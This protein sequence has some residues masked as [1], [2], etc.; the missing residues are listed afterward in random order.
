MRF[1]KVVD[2][3]RTQLA[4]KDVR[5]PAGRWQNPG[6]R[7]RDTQFEVTLDGRPLF[8]AEDRTFLVSGRVGLWTKAD[9]VTHFDGFVARVID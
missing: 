7:A 5:A 4:G 6:L 2:G 3:R 1:Y 9:S 8:T